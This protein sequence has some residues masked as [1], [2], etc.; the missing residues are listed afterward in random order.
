MFQANHLTTRAAVV[1]RVLSKASRV[2]S[3]PPRRLP[4]EVSE[5]VLSPDVKPLL[6]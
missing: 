1:V 2:R 6:G 4:A 3:L 5:F